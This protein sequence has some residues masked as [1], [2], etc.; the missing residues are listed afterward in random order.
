MGCPQADD[1][2]QLPV[3]SGRLLRHGYTWAVIYRWLGII[4]SF[5]NHHVHCPFY[6]PTILNAALETYKRKA[7]CQHRLSHS[8]N[9]VSF[10]PFQ[11]RILRSSRGRPQR[12]RRTNPSIQPI[13]EWR[14]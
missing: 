7:N 13:Q 10:A 4:H 2:C 8:L 1:N 3:A 6:F 11:H 9:L 14:Q 12:P 5:I